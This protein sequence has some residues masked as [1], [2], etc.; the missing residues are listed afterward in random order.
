MDSQL[1]IVINANLPLGQIISKRLAQKG[2][3]VVYLADNEQDGYAIAADEPRVRYRHC[4]T[5]DHGMIAG[6][7]DWATRYVGPVNGV[8]VVVTEGSIRQL[9]IPIEESFF[10]SLHEGLS[11]ETDELSLTY[12]IV[13]D[14]DKTCGQSLKDL[15]LK[16]CELSHQSNSSK[17]GI[18]VNHVVIGAHQYTQGPKCAVVATDASDLIHYLSSKNAKAVRH[19]AFYFGN[20]PD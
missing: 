14:D 13:P 6:E 18:K 2:N 17:T 19:Q 11:Q 20:S 12:V 7:F 9:S 4:L 8:V 1:Y 5:Y 16:L 15:H 3:T 10:A